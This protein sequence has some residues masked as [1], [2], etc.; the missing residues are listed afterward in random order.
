MVS[1]SVAAAAAVRARPPAA[2]SFDRR[3]RRR[4]CRQRPS[5]R[6]RSRPFLHVRGNVD[7]DGDLAGKRA[8]AIGQCPPP[9]PP[10]PQPP[11]QRAFATL[12]AVRTPAYE[13]LRVEWVACCHASR[14]IQLRPS[15]RRPQAV[16]LPN[17]AF[18]YTT[19]RASERLSR[20]AGASSL[21]PR[22]RR[23]GALEIPDGTERGAK[24]CLSFHCTGAGGGRA[25]ISH[26]RIT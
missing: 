17:C 12:G 16:R 15:V 24:S 13:G 1:S 22:P 20:F 11:V 7:P 8:A 26:D 5:L 2:R 25:F 9:Q 18:I 21:G 3:R 19:D 14:D 6:A 23:R 10:P 4:R